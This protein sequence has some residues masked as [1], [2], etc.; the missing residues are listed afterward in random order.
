M[1][2]YQKIVGTKIT[3]ISKS[4]IRNKW[5]RKNRKTN[6]IPNVTENMIK[7]IQKS[8]IYKAEENG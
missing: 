7:G 6:T 2:E 5:K 4:S 1:E 3:R 8:Q